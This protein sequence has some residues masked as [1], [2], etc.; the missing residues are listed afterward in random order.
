MLLMN[1]ALYKVI[2]MPLLFCLFYSFSNLEA[3][4][5]YPD[6]DQ[7]M[8]RI[9]LGLEAT[10]PGFNIRNRKRYQSRNQQLIEFFRAM[11]YKNIEEAA[12]DQSALRIPRIVHQIWIGSPVP[13][14]FREWMSTWMN[15]EG[16]EYKLWTDAEISQLSLYNRVLYDQSTNY[17]E[18]SDIVRLEILSMFGGVYVDVDLECINPEIFEELHHSFDFYIGFEPLEHGFTNKF[19]MFK[20]CNAIIASAPDHPLIRDLIE[21]LKANY[22]AYMRY[23]NAVQRTGPSY[24]TRLICEHEL[25]GTHHKRNMYLPCTFFYPV[26]EPETRYLVQHPELALPITS[27]TAGIHYWYG[28]WWKADRFDSNN[29]HIQK[30]LVNNR[31]EE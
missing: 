28:S 17:G 10:D 13:D 5:A 31:E 3:K 30:T 24:L 4:I 25:S 19:N 1:R 26:S 21:N 15:L 14:N 27:E 16:W 22:L 11:Y 9:G 8:L 7:S 2:M 12:H 29:G 20:V 18:K 23:C 6:F